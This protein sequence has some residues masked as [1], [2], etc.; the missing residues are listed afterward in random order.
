MRA[1]ESA[2]SGSFAS[3][4]ELLSEELLSGGD[5]GLCLRAVRE[6]ARRCGFVR[7][8]E[9][10]GSGSFASSTELLFCERGIGSAAALATLPL[11]LPST[12]RSGALI[13]ARDALLAA[14]STPLSPP[15]AVLSRPS[16]S[17][18]P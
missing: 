12:M 10:A 9:S 15:L 4:A 18:A 7:A 1:I 14:C 17:F 5:G 6:A 3:S 16:S 13:S 2:G 8:I 11:P